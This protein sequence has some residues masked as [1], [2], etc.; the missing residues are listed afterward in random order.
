MPSHKQNTEPEQN[1]ASNNNSLSVGG[2]VENSPVVIGNNNVVHHTNL[3]A[4]ELNENLEQL[5]DTLYDVY[6]R[7]TATHHSMMDDFSREILETVLISIATGVSLVAIWPYTRG[8]ILYVPYPVALILAMV[9]PV[10]R[11][12]HLGFRHSL[13]IGTWIGALFTGLLFLAERYT[14]IEYVVAHAP[15][16]AA[17]G[18]GLLGILIGATVGIIVTLTRPLGI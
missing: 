3:Q 5:N 16:V 17:L 18:H 6:E 1:I 11:I 15:V 2:D 8:F 10:I 14:T 12:T 7:N 4:D 9:F 13:I